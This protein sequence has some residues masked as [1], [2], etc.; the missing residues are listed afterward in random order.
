MNQRSQSYTNVPEK[1]N[2]WARD[3]TAR[4]PHGD[5][6][7]YF[8][9]ALIV[10]GHYIKIN[11][12]APENAAFLT[13]K[14]EKEFGLAAHL[15]VMLMGELLFQIRNQ[16]AFG[17]MCSRMIKRELRSSFFELLAAN[18]VFEN[19]FEIHSN[20]EIGVRG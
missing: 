20:G 15:R 17:E 5:W 4:F 6:R 1:L 13:I 14:S 7:R 16:P 3:M 11:L 8:Y 18:L 12:M 9:V 19:E 2:L 10:C